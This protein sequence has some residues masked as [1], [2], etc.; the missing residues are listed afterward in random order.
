MAE[1]LAKTSLTFNPTRK[2]WTA[3]YW[4]DS[5]LLDK[6]QHNRHAVEKKMASV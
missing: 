1:D 3:N 6:L 4:Y 2:R 5:T